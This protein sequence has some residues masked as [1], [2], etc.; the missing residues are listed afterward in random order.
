METKHKLSR[1]DLV[2]WGGENGDKLIG[3]VKG[4]VEM[5]R[6]AEVTIIGYRDVI[7]SHRHGRT[8]CMGLQYLTKLEPALD[9]AKYCGICAG[10][11]EG[12]ELL[13]GDT[14][15]RCVELSAPDTAPPVGGETGEAQ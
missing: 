8:I 12:E 10:L 3:I 14:C 2:Q 15:F 6:S 1:F 11:M 13:S 4:F 5:P 9:Q 7:D